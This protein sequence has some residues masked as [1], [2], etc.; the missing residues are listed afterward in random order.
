MAAPLRRRHTIEQ[1]RFEL[2]PDGVRY[3]DE[4][5][6]FSEVVSAWSYRVSHRTHYVGVGTDEHDPGFSFVLTMEDGSH[7]QV[8]EQS[9]WTYTS[10]QERIDSL[11]AAFNEICARTFQK[12]AEKYVHQLERKGFFNYAGWRFSPTDQTIRNIE[13]EDV[14]DTRET[15]FL[16]GYGFLELRP[17]SEGLADKFVRRAKL[18]LTGR[19]KG[20]GTLTDP[21]V[22]YALLEHYFGLRW[23]S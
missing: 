19:R 17:R 15:N 8:T 11:Q 13:S 21:D 23:T 14:F 7:V 16:R 12:R 6:S 18:E 20:I 4:A 10:K 1:T 9:T 5:Y 3:K 22:F 2:L